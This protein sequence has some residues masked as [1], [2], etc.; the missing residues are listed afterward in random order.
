MFGLRRSGASQDAADGQVSGDSS[1]TPGS[2]KGRPTPSRREAEEARKNQL[3]IPKDPKA[4]RK[5]ARE[6]DR[7]A[8][9]RQRQGMRTGDE[10]YLPARDRGPAKSFTRDFVDARV[11]VAEYFIFIAIGV[12]VM[13][14][15]PNRMIVAWVN[16]AFYAVTALI[17]V[18][19]AVLLF[20][21][22]RRARAAFPDAKDRKGI[23]LYAAIRALQIRRLRLPPPRVKRGGAPKDAPPAS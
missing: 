2:G 21:L 7:T 14:F 22:N 8:R 19:T 13:G 5:A 15:I 11:T 12:L 9:E 17:L 6:R 20:V 4:A 16:I 10:R 23:M 1:A 3:K 18:D